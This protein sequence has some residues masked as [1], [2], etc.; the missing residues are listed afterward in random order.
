MKSN[1]RKSKKYS[2][3]SSDDDDDDNEV[4]DGDDQMDDCD[5]RLNDV[6]ISNNYEDD[7]NGF[8]EQDNSSSV[9]DGQNDENEEIKKEIKAILLRDVSVLFISLNINAFPCIEFLKKLNASIHSIDA[10][11]SKK[12]T[13]L[14]RNHFSEF[15][16][17]IKDIQRR[18]KDKITRAVM[19]ILN[20]IGWRRFS[21]EDVSFVLHYSSI[22]EFNNIL[23]S[24]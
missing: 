4:E 7:D 18:L 21:V 8:D 9:F 20:K 22:H 14:V 15:S 10:D 19:Y 13:N 12:S 24:L 17:Q 16:I 5:D 23:L 3:D 11:L 6:D 1:N 2:H